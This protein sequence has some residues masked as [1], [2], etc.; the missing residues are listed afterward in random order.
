[1][2][3][4]LPESDHPVSTEQLLELLC[5]NQ[6]TAADYNFIVEQLRHAPP[7]ISRVLIVMM[8]LDQARPKR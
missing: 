1:M 7:A 8:L 5:P 3:A 6:L 4:R 2:A